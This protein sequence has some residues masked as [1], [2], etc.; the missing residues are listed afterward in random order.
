MVNLNK[1]DRAFLCGSSMNLAYV[2]VDNNYDA[3]NE[4]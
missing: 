3:E 4:P 1:R 2:T